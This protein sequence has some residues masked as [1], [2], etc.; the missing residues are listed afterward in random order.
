MTLM[1]QPLNQS[2]DFG[3]SAGQGLVES[4]APKPRG[5]RGKKGDPQM[6]IE[7]LLLEGMAGVGGKMSSRDG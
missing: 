3:A 6:E 5:L 4:V 2:R 7:T 1:C